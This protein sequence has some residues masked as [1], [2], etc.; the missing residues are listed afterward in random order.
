MSEQIKNDCN[1]PG[2]ELMNKVL[3][4]SNKKIDQKT[5]TIDQL[6]KIK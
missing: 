3:K 2:R 5:K 6:K 1:G 4:K